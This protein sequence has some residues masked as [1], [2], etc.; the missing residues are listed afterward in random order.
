MVTPVVVVGPECPLVDAAQIMVQ[1]KIGCLPVVED[2]ELVG[3][4]TEMDA[5]RILVEVLG[6][7]EPGALFTVQLLDAPGTLAAMTSAVAKAGGNIISITQSSAQDGQRQVTVKEK[8]ADGTGAAPVFAGS[9]R[10]CRL[11][12]KR[13]AISAAP[14]QINPQAERVTPGSL[15]RPAFLC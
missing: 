14:C 15:S 13:A 6:G 5:L 7:G 4:I 11:H 9:Q 2:D 8:G 10:R 1:R 3:I 12:S